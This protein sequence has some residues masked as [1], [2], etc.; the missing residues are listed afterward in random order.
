[1]A[2]RAGHFANTSRSSPINVLFVA[3]GPRRLPASV[4]AIELPQ[5]TSTS[6]ADRLPPASATR[7]DDDDACQVDHDLRHYAIR[8]LIGQAGLLAI[9]KGA[10]KLSA[11][12]NRPGDKQPALFLSVL[13]LWAPLGHFRRPG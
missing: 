5:S 11:P 13:A 10:A 6:T 9:R 12:T 3:P 1:M 8:L 7:P 4:G 2:K